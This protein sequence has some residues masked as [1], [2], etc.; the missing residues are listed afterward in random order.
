MS[1]T[2]MG[3]KEIIQVI[4]DVGQADYYI[5]SENHVDYLIQEGRLPNLKRGGWV[6]NSGKDFITITD[7]C[8]T[9]V[10]LE[11]DD[12]YGVGESIVVK[13]TF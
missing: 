5:K 13:I 3:R 9:T 8:V 10:P 2:G 1:N 6:I 11:H 12:L 4:S 7:L